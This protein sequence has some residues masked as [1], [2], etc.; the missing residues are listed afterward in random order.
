MKELQNRKKKIQN[1]E[2]QKSEKE[3]IPEAE[4]LIKEH[5]SVGKGQSVQTRD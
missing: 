2:G 1:C 5:I 4:D 3:V